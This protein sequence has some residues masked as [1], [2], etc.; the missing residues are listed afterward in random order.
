[1]EL[2]KRKDSN[3]LD[4]LNRT[5][6]SNFNEKIDINENDQAK[7]KQAENKEQIIQSLLILDTE[8]TGLDEKEDEVIEIGCKTAIAISKKI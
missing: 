4:L 6:R 2:P 5:L 1:M 3:Q 8:T 7:N